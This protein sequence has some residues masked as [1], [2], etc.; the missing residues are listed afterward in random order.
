MREVR[1]GCV[2]SHLF[3]NLY[4]DNIFREAVEDRTWGIIAKGVV[5]KNVRYADDTVL[6]AT[7]KEDLQ[8]DLSTVT[9]HASI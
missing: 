9:D 8:E 2:L 6:L 1:Q 5:I 3:I 4:T 7:D